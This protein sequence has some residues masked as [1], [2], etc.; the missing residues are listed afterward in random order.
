LDTICSAVGGEGK[1]NPGV[2]GD[3]RGYWVSH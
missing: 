1:P 2:V 3:L